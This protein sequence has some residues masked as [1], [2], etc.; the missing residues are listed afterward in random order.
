MREQMVGAMRGVEGV[1]FVHDVRM[2]RAGSRYFADVAVGIPRNT[3]FQRSEQIVFAATA[4]VQRVIPGT[5]VVVRTVP[6]A[7]VEESVFDRVRAVAQRSN[8][9]IHDVSVQQVEDGLAVDL[10]LELPERMPLRE[11]HETATRIEAEMRS[12]VPEIRS[13]ITHI[14]AEESTIETAE[15]VANDRLLE[16]E[17]CHAAEAFPEIE[18]VHNIVALRKGD[19]VQISCHCSM[20]DDLPMGTVHRIISQMEAAF[21][22]TRPEVD[23]LLIHPEPVTDN[24]R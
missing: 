12:E 11:A 2:R 21:L 23:R 4:A 19:H 16:G 18:D 10:H 3:T 1:L 24:N 6:T 5:D 13:V 14:E 22:R 7:Q 15:R 20:P 17:V 9:A 8:H